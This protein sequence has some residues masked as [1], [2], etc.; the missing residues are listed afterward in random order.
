MKDTCRLPST[1]NAVSS[2]VPLRNW[3]PAKVVLRLYPSFY[4]TILKSC[5]LY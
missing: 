4:N 3:K 2:V 5:G 1:S